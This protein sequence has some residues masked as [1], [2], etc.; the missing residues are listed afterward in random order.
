MK[1]LET[2][3]GAPYLMTQNDERTAMGLAKQRKKEKCKT[4]VEE[5]LAQYGSQP[6]IPRRYRVDL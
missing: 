6:P 2:E 5:E 1:S 4:L 3:A